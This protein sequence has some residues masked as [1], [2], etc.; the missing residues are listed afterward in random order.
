MDTTGDDIVLLVCNSTPSSAPSRGAARVIWLLVKWH[1]AV[2]FCFVSL[3][4]A[5]NLLLFSLLYFQLGTSPPR[6]AAGNVTFPFRVLVAYSRPPRAMLAVRGSFLA[7]FP[8][9]QHLSFPSIA[10]LRAFPDCRAY[11]FKGVGL[12]SEWVLRSRIFDSCSRSWNR[13]FPHFPIFL[14]FRLVRV[15]YC[16]GTALEGR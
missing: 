3:C 1:K 5:C 2:L 16:Y 9:S 8:S 4:Y 10:I 15:G 14:R 11:P 7:W 13:G 12:V 6:A